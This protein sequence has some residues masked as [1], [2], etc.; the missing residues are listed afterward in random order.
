LALVEGEADG[1]PELGAQAEG[2]VR[3]GEQFRGLL[4]MGS[5]TGVVELPFREASTLEGEV[6]LLQRGALLR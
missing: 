6:A 5:R 4:V 1:V 2:T 3:A